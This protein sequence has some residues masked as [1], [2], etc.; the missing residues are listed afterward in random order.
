MRCVCVSKDESLTYFSV[1][2]IIGG[3]KSG[4]IVVNV[5]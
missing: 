5:G 4:G 3:V 2:S 1:S